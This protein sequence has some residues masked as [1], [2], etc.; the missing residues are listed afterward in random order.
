MNQDLRYALRTLLHAPAFTIVAVLTL[1]LGIG[2]TTAIFSIFDAVILKSL[3]VNKPNELF[4]VNAGHYG[5]YQALRKENAIFSDVLAA[6]PIEELPVAI[7]D[8][9]GVTGRVSLVS[10]SYF[11]TLGVYASRGRV[12]GAGDDRAPG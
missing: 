11:A 6:A 1:G 4:I 5:L 12:F 7:R 10:A 2:A 9:Q 3:P 8:E